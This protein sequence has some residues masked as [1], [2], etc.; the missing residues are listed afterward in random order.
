MNVRD[1]FHITVHDYPGGA[2]SL[3][4]RMGMSAGVLRNKANPNC[5]TNQPTLVDADRLIAVTGN[6]TL[7]HVL[8][9]NHSHV[10]VPV[11]SSAPACDTAVLEIIAQVWSAQGD[12]GKAVE[13]AL[14]D[15]RVEPHE[16]RQVR[17]A[18]YRMQQ[19]L[20]TLAARLDQMSEP[21]VKA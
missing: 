20:L 21:E 12:V 15:H 14:A 2:E 7:L 19:S 6:T 4:P 10:A 8:C 13:E 5:L 9:A 16:V 11:D 18:I 1:A 17:Q 3:A